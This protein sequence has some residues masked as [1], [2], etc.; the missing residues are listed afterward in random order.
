MD[1][2]DVATLADLHFRCKGLTLVAQGIQ[3]AAIGGIA[4][5][6]A[7]ATVDAGGRLAE[8]A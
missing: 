8:D 2:R 5:H 3:V 1:N 6:Y 7:H 4:E